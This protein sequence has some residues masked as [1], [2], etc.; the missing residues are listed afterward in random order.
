MTTMSNNINAGSQLAHLRLL[1]RQVK[2]QRKE[3][4]IKELQ[5][6]DLDDSSKAGEHFEKTMGEIIRPESAP[7]LNKLNADNARRLAVAQPNKDEQTF[8][9]AM[10]SSVLMK[11][12]EDREDLA[13]SFDE[14]AHENGPVGDSSEAAAP[15]MPAGNYVNKLVISLGGGSQQQQEQSSDSEHDAQII[16]FIALNNDKMKNKGLAPEVIEDVWACVNENVKKNINDKLNSSKNQGQAD[17][18]E[19]IEKN[20]KVSRFLTFKKLITEFTATKTIFSDANL[21]K[22]MLEIRSNFPEEIKDSGEIRPRITPLETL[23]SILGEIL[24]RSLSLEDTQDKCSMMLEANDFSLYAIH[25]VWQLVEVVLDTGDKPSQA[26]A[27]IIHGDKEIRNFLQANINEANLRLSA[28][29]DEAARLGKSAVGSSREEIEK[30]ADLNAG[31]IQLYRLAAILDFLIEACGSEL[32]DIPSKIAKLRA[33]Y[34]ARVNQLD[35]SNKQDILLA[36]HLR[37][38]IQVIIVHSLY[39]LMSYV[40]ESPRAKNLGI[41]EGIDPAVC[42]KLLISFVELPSLMKMNVTNLLRDLGFN[43]NQNPE[44]LCLWLSEILRKLPLTLFGSQDKQ[45]A[46]RKRVIGLITS[47][48]TSPKAT[49][50][51]A[52]SSYTRLRNGAKP[53]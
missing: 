12:L 38:Q 22:L 39:K 36:A 13:D 47:L 8:L 37:F 16:A 28:V 9:A 20:R 52:S 26:S 31:N 30:I 21:A 53:R 40:T 6:H 35:S 5:E 42:V 33:D 23:A 46:N 1:T 18:S 10:E 34:V 4:L 3:E 41:K 7:K 14:L 15:G 27:T 48:S 17:N 2:Q 11:Q 45:D 43:P 50:Q 51:A 25:L 29:F 49:P 32:S 44:E 19:F 24:K